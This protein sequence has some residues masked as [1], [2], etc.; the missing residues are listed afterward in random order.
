M[1]MTGG[2]LKIGRGMSTGALLTC[3][4]FEVLGVW[5]LHVGE[6]AGG[7]DCGHSAPGRADTTPNLTPPG[8]DPRKKEFGKYYLDEKFSEKGSVTMRVTDWK[9]HVEDVNFDDENVKK[10]FYLHE[11]PKSMNGRGTCSVTFGSVLG[12]IL[13]ASVSS[14]WGDYGEKMHF[15]PIRNPYRR[16]IASW[17]WADEARTVRTYR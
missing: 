7:G 10:D 13:S 8:R 1:Q 5:K 6:W 17:G 11:D 12:V 14:H 15:S 2:V 4:Q 3:A 16:L 9:V